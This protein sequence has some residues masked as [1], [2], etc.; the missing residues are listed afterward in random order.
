MPKGDQADGFGG[1]EG[2]IDA[3]N[4]VHFEGL[5]EWLAIRGIAI[6]QCG[7]DLILDRAIQL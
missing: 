2:E 7:E 4:M 3:S 1:T 5:M 6:Q